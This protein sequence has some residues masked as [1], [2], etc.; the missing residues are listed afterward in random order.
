MKGPCRAG[1]L[2]PTNPMLPKLPIDPV[3]QDR[4]TE[5]K[6]QTM[7]D[8]M[9][10]VDQEIEARTGNATAALRKA[11]QRLEADER[12]DFEPLTP[13]EQADATAELMAFVK[14]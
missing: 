10:E 9:Y 12:I 13:I 7:F 5:T 14:E 2:P 8:V 4:F 1:L 6:D 11:L 3:R